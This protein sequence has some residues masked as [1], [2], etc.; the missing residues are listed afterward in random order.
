MNNYV[1]IIPARGGSKGIK[2]KNLQPIGTLPMFVY[3]VVAARSVSAIQQ[4]IVS[5][6]DATI[7]EQAELYGA[8]PHKRSLHAATD[9]A[10]TESVVYNVLKTVKAD[11]V[12]LIQPTSPMLL[13]EHLIK[14]IEKFERG[15]Y[16]S[17]FS[18]SVMED[19][20]V[21]DKISMYPINYD[22]QRRMTRQTRRRALLWENGA[23]FITKRN[24]YIEQHSRL[25][26]KI[27]YHEMP[28]WRSFQVDDKDDLQNIRT[29]MTLKSKER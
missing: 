17:L 5:S 15:G 11:N 21:W 16:D 25:G 8:I 10:S 13:A 19:M 27:G 12:V 6:D 4:V 24:V 14:G 23:F 7:L 29:L 26:G 18:A 2:K 22:P 28:F 1:A 3:S 20:L 9:G